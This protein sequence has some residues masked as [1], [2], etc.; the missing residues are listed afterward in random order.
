MKD[1]G[2][3][4]GGTS[5]R[6]ADGPAPAGQGPAARLFAALTGADPAQGRR[7][8]RPGKAEPANFLRHA[9]ALSLTK[10][11]DGLIDPK[12]VLSWLMAA[13][14]APAF[15][16]GLL[17][18]MRE[19][20]ALLPQIF[21][22]PWVK[23]MRRRKWAWVIGSAVQGLAAAGIALAGYAGASGAVSPLGAGGAIVALVGVLAVAR[24]LCSVS[25]KDVL[26]RTVGRS[27]RG[28]ATGLAASLSAAGVVIFATWLMLRGGAGTGFV[29]GAI[30]LAGLFWI[31]AAALF[32]TIKEE[33]ASP[34]ADPFHRSV[35]QQFTLLADDR[36]LALF[37]AVRGLLV[38][39][40]LAPPY[41]IVLAA[42]G[43]R[44]FQQL[45][46][47]VLA[48]AAASLL[49]SYVW[50]RLADRSSRRV[51]IGAGIAG[52]GALAAGLA[53]WAAGQLGQIWA[54][55]LVL[56]ALMV[57]YHGVRQGR[58]TY[59]VDM[60]PR[61]RRAEYT[62]VANTAIGLLLLL[63]GLGGALVAIWG[64]APALGIFA[65]MSL[66]AA[67]LARRLKE[68]EE[69]RARS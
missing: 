4:Q 33:P 64:P 43:G 10:T 17:V 41:L 2:A 16:V 54:V 42:E 35:L 9:G 34:V 7:E 56:F 40:A 38:S 58:S 69:A 68:V 67:G 6:R 46:A 26:G 51:L 53:L 12:L 23:G 65:A 49:S 37:V 52:A 32:S 19:G 57:A 11:A 5:H 60:A 15:L 66:G 18:P 30:L 47:L 1:Q 62:A 13:L 55:T 21:L 8:T 25:Y 22:A 29:L 50:G 63:A 36:Q 27:R 48:S 59:L 14:G 61:D 24:S 44:A 45:G 3:A 28:T 39:T 31:V 20:G